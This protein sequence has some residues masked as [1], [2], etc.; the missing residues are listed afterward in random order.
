MTDLFDLLASLTQA[1]GPSGFEGGVAEVIRPLWEPLV[2]H[3]RV[4][5][6]GSLV[7]VRPGQGGP[8]RRR[9]LLAGHMDEIGLM[10]KAIDVNRNGA[11]F[12]R[13]TPVGGVDRRH[14]YG[15]PVIVHGRLSGRHDLPGVLGALP[16]RL[17]PE[18]AWGQAFEYEHLLV[19]VGL[20][21][22]TL[23][24]RV[25]V[26]DFISF[27]QPL[28]KLQGER[29]AGKALDNRAAVAAITVCLKLLQTRHHAWDVVAVATAQEET[30]LLGAYT[31][32]FD[33]QPDVALAVDVTFGNG[34][35]AT[36]ALTFGLGKGPTV[37]LGPNV[38]PAVHKG[39]REA[40]RAIELTVHDEPHARASGTDAMGLQIARE[41]I[42]TG[43]I[44]IPL[45]YMHT[46]V[47][48]L[49]LRDVRRAGRLLAE[50][51]ARLDESFLTTLT[52]ALT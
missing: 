24:E 30:A 3:I 34:P 11:G 8:P 37:G 46:P 39:L 43:V 52:E 17:L 29:V 5:R 13:V 49:D 4:D 22:A 18:S 40:A 42:P 7:A 1:P 15:Q 41:G 28:H 35:G 2:D 10:V 32:S 14:L 33:Q 45:R 21:A 26:G 23:R 51:A 47:E 12:L 16:D 20:P 36:D 44:G 6:I 19:D 48:S 38:H 9:L 50:F 31:S 27:R 25:S